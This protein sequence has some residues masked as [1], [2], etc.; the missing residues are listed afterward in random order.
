LIFAAPPSEACGIRTT[1]EYNDWLEKLFVE[2]QDPNDPGNPVNAEKSIKFIRNFIA[3]WFKY[4]HKPTGM[5][6]REAFIESNN[7]PIR[8]S[9]IEAAPDSDLLIKAIHEPAFESEGLIAKGVSLGAFRIMA[10]NALNATTDNTEATT[11]DLMAN[12]RLNW[13]WCENDTWCCT[14]VAYLHRDEFGFDGSNPLRRMV[15]VPDANHFVSHSH[16]LLKFAVGCSDTHKIQLHW[17][18]PGKFVENMLPLL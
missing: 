3:G 7:H 15:S 8:P 16:D 12:K 5:V 4:D 2:Q 17:E 14:Y 18:N 9:T 13:L 10:L 6:D 1:D 11:E